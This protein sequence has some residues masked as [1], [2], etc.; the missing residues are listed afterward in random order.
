MRIGYADPPYPGQ[1]KRLYGEHEAYAGEVNHVQLVERLTAEY[2]AWVLHTSASAL[3][4]ILPLC[5]AP[6]SRRRRTRADT[7]KA[8]GPGCS[9]GSSPGPSGGP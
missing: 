9:S 8:P 3:H 2:D 4:E 1:S 6:R 7:S 5:P